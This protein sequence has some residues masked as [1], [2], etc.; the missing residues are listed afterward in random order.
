MNLKRLSAE[1]ITAM[2]A[3]ASHRV[4]A[5]KSPSEI[6]VT[7]VIQ[8]AV[9]EVLFYEKNPRRHDNPKYE[10]IKESIRIRGLESALYITKRPGSS[11]YMLARGGKTRLKALQELAKEDLQKWGKLDFHEIPWVS[12][13]EILAAHLVENT[14][15]EAMCF[16]DL[17]E[18]IATLRNQIAQEMGKTVSHRALPELLSG[19]GIEVGRTTIQAGTFALD[20]LKALGSWKPS[21]SVKHIE[22]IIR[23]K[24][25][26]LQD[27]WL[28]KSP[29]DEDGFKSMVDQAVGSCVAEHS[30]YSPELLV[31]AVV[32][33][34]ATA[35]EVTT[36]GMLQALH[37]HQANSIRSLD[38]LLAIAHQA[39]A[40]TGDGALPPGRNPHE[41]TQLP[42]GSGTGFAA[43][44]EIGDHQAPA[45]GSSTNGKPVLS[46]AARQNLNRLMGSGS[47]RATDVP[48]I[49]GV[50]VARGL[51]PRRPKTSGNGSGAGS[52][53]G[54][55]LT[56][57][58][59]ALLE[60][61][62]DKGLARKV[63]W[64]E[65]MGFGDV[66]GIAHLINESVSPHMPYGFYVE[67]PEPGHLG[68]SPDDIAVQAWWFLAAVSSQGNGNVLPLLIGPDAP[69][70]AFKEAGPGS[71]AEAM[72][73]PQALSDAVTHRLG[74]QAIPGFELLMMLITRR[75]HPLHQHALAVLD[76][77]ANWNFAMRGQ[78]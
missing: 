60:Q 45:A 62:G 65:L 28:L 13:S 9:D 39:A 61:E 21:L 10:E 74:G 78:P 75:D 20:F 52:V 17:A 24:F 25:T 73:E 38:E 34:V 43:P 8:L 11:Q 37:S 41:D 12:E 18:G 31:S 53:H 16:W 23:P 5:A 63:L 26:S 32:V 66:A 35:I 48:G 40:D 71:F 56:Q 51:T 7:S 27:L 44:A 29:S 68:A 2:T 6:H 76:A 49:P 47:A 50:S 77:L 1:E 58:E 33:T 30:Q 59:M 64:S 70:C 55:P 19:R 15:R 54:G 22:T 67:L 46:D 36:E 42:L 3:A 57:E 72:L 69:V 4:I 14:E